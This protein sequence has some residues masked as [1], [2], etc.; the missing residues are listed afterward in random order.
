MSF[1]DGIFV[2][3]IRMS[4]AGRYFIR[5]RSVSRLSWE[6]M[7]TTGSFLAVSGVRLNGT[8]RLSCYTTGYLTTENRY[9]DDPGFSRTPDG[10]L[11]FISLL[12]TPTRKLRMASDAFPDMQVGQ[13]HSRHYH[14]P[15]GYEAIPN[16]PMPAIPDPRVPEN[17]QTVPPPRNLSTAFFGQMTAWSCQH[18]RSS[19][20]LT[21]TMASEVLKS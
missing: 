4:G 9:P 10:T 6:D 17:G 5:S 8:G 7:S 12:Q 2:L 16:P 14:F 3:N 19:S 15:T 21:V 13:V 11:P 1:T 18:G 20:H